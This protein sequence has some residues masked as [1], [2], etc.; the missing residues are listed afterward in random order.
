MG[1]PA[2]APYFP[3]AQLVQDV[4]AATANA[5]SGQSPLQAAEDK[6]GMAPYFPEGQFP[7]HPAVVRPEEAPYFPAG[8][9]VQEMDAAKAK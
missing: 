1:R 4:D 8:Q 3:A 6:P 9:L 7:V 2:V 5:P